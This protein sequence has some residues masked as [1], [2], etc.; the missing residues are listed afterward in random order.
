MIIGLLGGHS[1]SG[2][3]TLLPAM[4]HLKTGK[5]RALAVTTQ[6]RVSMLPDVPAL[7]ETLPGFDIA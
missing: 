3:A 4:Q 7:S 1:P 6:K 5:L 2:F